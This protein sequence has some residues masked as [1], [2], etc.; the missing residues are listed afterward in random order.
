MQQMVITVVGDDRAGLVEALAAEVAAVDGNW[1]RSRMAELGGQFAGMVLVRVPEGQADQLGERLAAL[2]AD[3]VLHVSVRPA[4]DPAGVA[5]TTTTA[6][7]WQL[8]LVGQDQP[9]IVHRVSRTLAAEG[10]SVAELETEVVPAPM[11]GLLFQAEADLA[12]PASVPLDE[13]RA[14]LEALSPDLMVDLDPV[15][16]PG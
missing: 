9:G 6:A 3:G 16:Q 10:I 5:T 11:G 7:R 2:H 14:A 15:D 8:R 13:V 1:E 12:V 4:D